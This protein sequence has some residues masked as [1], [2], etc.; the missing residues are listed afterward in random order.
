MV[1]G[2][3]ARTLVWNEKYQLT[4]V[5]S[6]TYKV[7][8]SYDVLGRRIGRTAGTNSESY[9]YNGNQVVADL[10]A[11]GTLLR[12]YA[13]G[14]GIDNLLSVT[15]HSKSSTNTY[16][17][18]KDHQNSVLGLATKNGN[19]VESYEYDAWGRVVSIKDGSGNVLSQSAIGNRYLWQGRE[20]DAT[21]GLYF[22]RAR[23]YSPETGRWLS[24]DPIG[25]SGGLNMYVFCANNPV[26]FTDPLGLRWFG[27]GDDGWSAGRDP[28]PVLPGEGH[29]GGWL[30]VNVPAMETMGNMHDP[31]VGA[32]VPNL[33]EPDKL[34]TLTEK[35]IDGIVNVPTMPAVYAAAVATE[36]ARSAAGLFAAA[37]NA[38]TGGGNGCDGKK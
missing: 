7:N 14:T 18:L 34:D 15:I 19:I 6:A 21:T 38:L 29:F 13:W 16:Y 37:F 35:V 10:D 11:N 27:S 30:E 26:N 31:L 9:V 23:W 5:S 2:A 36:T 33:G 12:T 22:F 8:Y 24:K 25:I 28:S 20:Y 4:S 32:L 17:A 3:S 1:T